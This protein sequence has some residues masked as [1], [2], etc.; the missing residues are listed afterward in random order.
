[1]GFNMKQGG[2][3]AP[4]PN[5]NVTP[6]VDIVLVL[7]IIF[8]VMTPMMTKTFWLNLPKKLDENAKP[9]VLSPNRDGP[10]VLTVDEAGVVRVNK[11]VLAESDFKSRL[12]RLIAASPSPV[13]YFDAHDQA[14]YGKAMQVMDLA[15]ANGARSIAILTKSV[16]KSASK[17]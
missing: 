4:S 15:R 6:L 7:L 11:E 12:P 17:L 8:M 1:M 16:M 10:L 14:P 2:K 13:L 9:A 3:A 5:V